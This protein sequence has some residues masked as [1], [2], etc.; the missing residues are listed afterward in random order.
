MSADFI[1]ML[2]RFVRRLRAWPRRFVLKS[3]GE[4]CDLLEL[5][6]SDGR[7][8]CLVRLQSGRQAMVTEDELGS[9]LAT[10]GL[11][12]AV[13]GALALAG[14]LVGSSF[15]LA[16]ADGLMADVATCAQ[17]IKHATDL[18]GR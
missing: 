7:R 16:Q 13:C 12:V 4:P 1:S 15:S 3:T 6:D 8:R 2:E 9:E 11:A 17:A 5:H 10:R 14:V 18:I